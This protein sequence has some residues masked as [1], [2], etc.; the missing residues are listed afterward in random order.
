[1]I[2]AG[3][4]ALLIVYAYRK[5]KDSATYKFTVL[6]GFILG[7]II[8]LVAVTRYQNW[9]S[10][11]ALLVLLAGFTL[12]I[13]PLTKVD[14]V[15]L[16]AL[17]VMGI[18]YIYLGTLTGSF[19]ILSDGYPRI[20]IAVLAGSFIYMMFHFLE[21]VVQLFGKILNCWP[22]LAILGLLCLAEGV[23]MLAEYDSIF[24][25]IKSYIE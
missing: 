19:E 15:I 5:D 8:M 17:L 24:T 3:L 7:I 9:T 14:F 6:V 23:L 22:I 20:I 10:A 1:M 13:R 2:L 16:L 4:M 12:F 11:D 21:K 25:I 18:V